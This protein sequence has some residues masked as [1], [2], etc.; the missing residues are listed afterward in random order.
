MEYITERGEK[1]SA[2]FTDAEK[3]HQ[4]LSQ[5]FLGLWAGETDYDEQRFHRLFK[6]RADGTVRL[7]EAAFDGFKRF[8]GTISQYLSA[9]IGRNAPIDDENFRRKL[10][11]SYDLLDRYAS[12]WT[13]YDYPNLY[14]SMP[15]NVNMVYWPGISWGAL[16]IS[17]FV[18]MAESLP[19]HNW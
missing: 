12:G 15:E 17:F 4:K 14:I 7:S 2:I 11:L 13:V 19:T 8:D 16:T 6:P 18:M 3:N 5:E 9:Y 10:L 1:E